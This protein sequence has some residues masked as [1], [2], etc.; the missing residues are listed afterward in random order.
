MPKRKTMGECIIKAKL[1]ALKRLLQTFTPSISECC[2]FLGHESQDCQVE[3]S[4]DDYEILL[5]I[6]DQHDP[7]PP[8]WDINYIPPC[9]R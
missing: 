5:P 3:N 1:E 7:H 4:Y 2:G 9:L 8:K 6:E